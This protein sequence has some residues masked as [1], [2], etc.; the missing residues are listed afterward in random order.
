MGIFDF[1]L[2]ANN[3]ESRKVARDTSKCGIIVSTAYTSDEG[4]ETALIDDS[5]VYPVER[6]GTEEQ[7]EQGHKKWLEFAHD[8]NGKQITMLEG[9]GGFAPAKV[10]TIVCK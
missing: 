7:A 3:Y 6:Y 4:F 1:L 2:D 8:A 9:I 10:V 5:D